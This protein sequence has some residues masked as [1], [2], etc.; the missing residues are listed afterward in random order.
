MILFDLDGTLLDSLGDL[1]DSTNYALAQ[2]GC[3]P[4]TMDEVRRFVGNGARELIRK[5]LPGTP[6]DPPVDQVLATYQA[7]YA[8]HAR[9]KTKPYDGVLEALEQISQR[10]PVAIVSN[11]PDVATKL[12]SRELF[13][14][15]PA[16]GESADCARKPAPDMLYKA[17]EALGA[18]KCIYVG[19]SEVDVLTAKNAGVPCLSV[20]WGFRDRDCL[21]QA[22]A[23]HFCSDPLTMPQMLEQIELGG[24]SHG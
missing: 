13:G 21:V 10:F 2:Y 3:P 19:D 1:T 8:T 9:I 22:G 17:M 15:L 6:N 16:W 11:K 12:L 4:R 18:E 7:Y 20:L 23:T 14:D 24:N 5:A